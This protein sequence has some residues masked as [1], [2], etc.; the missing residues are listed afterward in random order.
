[1]PAGLRNRLGTSAAIAAMVL[2]SGVGLLG[3]GEAWQRSNSDR[4]Q[5]VV[6]VVDNLDRAISVGLATTANDLA[7][8]A[9][10]FVALLDREGVVF[11]ASANVDPS[12]VED[13]AV[14]D[15][16]VLDMSEFDVPLGEFESGDDTWNAAALVCSDP[17][18]CDVVVVGLAPLGWW[19]YLWPRLPVGFGAVLGVGLLTL[20]GARWLVGRALDPVDRMR[21]E[22]EAITATGLDQRIEVGASGDELESLGATMND[23]ISRLA[24][25]LEAQKR[26]VSDSA[27]ELKSP[28]AGIRATLELAQPDPARQQRAI[29]ASIAH[30][31]RT[32]A[33]V[34]DLLV[35]A[36]H[37][38]ALP[39]PREL[40]D[41]D[42]IVR[43]ELSELNV[44]QPTLAIRRG[45]IEP[46]QDL[47][48]AAAI[49]RLTRN[50]LDNAFK[51]G[52]DQV[53]VALTADVR[54]WTLTV[55]DNGVGIAPEDRTS[56]FERFT[57]LDASRARDSG[58][59]GLGL[60]IVS[61]VVTD[62]GGEV[63]VEQ[64]EL[65]GAL[66][67]VTVPRSIE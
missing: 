4:A 42:D 31:D 56:V 65:G 43:I 17:T 67:R 16:G 14:E 3:L 10:V 7:A 34:D 12:S 28:L 51:H 5:S 21:R 15:L 54:V 18:K 22:L 36:R 58:G 8:D 60:A 48:D 1:M 23:T 19:T 64:S 39:V 47:V 63:A 32:T 27:H 20:L 62:H 41:I 57:R 38:A 49:A 2:V 33:I 50:L 6:D 61:S 9:N 66:F 52:N 44:R 13:F 24:G 29:D 45:S 46:V 25:S 37:D 35:L 26:F 59:S 55:E 40:A 30:I 53:S 11:D